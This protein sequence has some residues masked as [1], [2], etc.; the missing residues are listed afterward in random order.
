MADDV[1]RQ[2]NLGYDSEADRMLLRAGSAQGAEFRIWLTRRFVMLALGAIDKVLGATTSATGGGSLTPEQRQAVKAFK[3]E[4]AIGRTDFATPY[5]E[6]DSLPFG[7]NGVL[8]HR[9]S[10]TP[11]AN[12]RI[13]VQIQDKA[14]KG[15]N[16]AM[17]ESQVFAIRKLLLDT[18]EQA[19]WH[20]AAAAVAAGGARP[21]PAQGAPKG[22]S[23][24]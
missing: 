16:V 3:E 14:G 2:V 21:A 19:Q 9:F 1:L 15:L 10:L 7:E 18:A 12:G 17:P 8:A 5:A 6:G 23:I 20:L 24:N 4:D 13:M 22:V 11:Q